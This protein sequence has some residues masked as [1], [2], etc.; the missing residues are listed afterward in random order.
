MKIRMNHTSIGDGYLTTDHPSSSYNIPVFV[1]DDGNAYGP[2]D[3]FPRF[4]CNV[5]YLHQAEEVEYTA[6]EIQ[7]VHDYIVR[8]NLS[9]CETR[10]GARM[11]SRWRVWLFGET[12]KTAGQ[13]AE[14]E[15]IN[16]KKMIRNR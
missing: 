10:T 6:E 5:G 11:D 12:W 14:I 3:K 2:G 8:T 16:G 1:D 13:L 4:N 15:R 7:W 9:D